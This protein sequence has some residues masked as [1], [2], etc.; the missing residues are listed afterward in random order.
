LK[1]SIILITFTASFL[2]GIIESFPQVVSEEPGQVQIELKELY[3]LSAREI[4]YKL[5]DGYGLN[6]SFQSDN[7]VFDVPVSLPGKRTINLEELLDI[8]ERNLPYKYIIER[9]YIIFQRKELADNYVISGFVKDA[10]TGEPMVA[11]SIYI[12]DSNKG[13]LTDDYG[14]FILQ[15]P[16]GSYKIGFKYMGYKTILKHVNLYDNI[17]LSVF[18]ETSTSSI[19][20]VEIVGKRVFMG[21]FKKGRTIEIIESRE[22]EKLTANNAADALHARI[23]GVWATKTSGAPGDH[24]KIRIRGINSLFASVDPLYVVD[25]VPVPKVNLHS[26]GISDLNINDIESITV[27]KDASSTAIYGYRG[28]NGVIIIDTKHGGGGKYVSF[29]FKTGVQWFNKRYD[30][31]N[32]YDFLQTYGFS[33]TIYNTYFLRPEITKWEEYTAKYPD[34]N[35]TLP[36]DDWQDYIFQ[37]GRAN[38][39]QLNTGGEINKIQ[40]Y[41]SGNHYTHDGIIRNSS[42][43]KNSLAANLSYDFK[44]KF[45]VALNYKGSNQENLNNIDNYLGNPVIF[46]GINTEPGFRGTPDTYLNEGNRLLYQNYEIIHRY[47]AQYLATDYI[48]KQH[49]V[50]NS[51]HLNIKAL[52]LPNL[53]I[54]ASGAFNIRQYRYLLDDKQRNWVHMPSSNYFSYIRKLHLS[55]DERVALLNQNFDLIYTLNKKMQQIKII[56]GLRNYSDNVFWSLDSTSIDDNYMNEH[57]EI[58]SRGSMAIYGNRGSTVRKIRSF[59]SHLNYNFNNKYTISLAGNFSHLFEDYSFDTKDFFPSVALNWNLAKEPI[60]NTI[61]QIDYINLYANWGKVGNYPLV[62]LSK[63]IYNQGSYIRDTVVEAEYINNLANHYIKNEQAFEYNLG[64]RLSLF[65]QRL[66]IGFDYYRKSNKDLILLHDI[67]YYYGG[68]TIMRN[69]GEM[70]STGREYSIQLVPVETYHFVWQVRANLSRNKQRVVSLLDT[71][72]I[73]FYDESELYPDFIINRNDPLGN[74]I[75]YKYVGRKEDV[76]VDN[77]QTEDELQADG[78]NSGLLPHQ[79]ESGGLVFEKYDTVSGQHEKTVIGNSIP[80]YTFNFNSSFRYKQIQLD[81]TLYGAFGVQKYN[82]TRASTYMSGVNSDMHE[83]MLDTLSF[84]Q[85]NF[86]YES[87]YFVED[88]SFLR[89]KTISVSYSP[90]VKWFKAVKPEITI[91]GENLFTFTSYRGYDPETSVYTDNNFSDNAIDR[92]A[93]PIPMGI[94]TSLKLTF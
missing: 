49:I 54:N 77:L 2:L 56:C 19:K 34:Y 76:V 53:F 78:V 35:L 46:K 40:Y 23:P 68:G 69:I 48:N 91:T 36:S 12:V 11:V 7:K 26:L 84:Y 73:V 58:F 1:K 60:L 45:M 47:G 71:V 21:D 57:R 94:Y 18:L 4:L 93:Y 63:D 10:G 92:G 55:S 9:E 25:G 52:V 64:T 85:Y 38:E 62:S 6:I 28:G 43:E 51:L 31:M 75:G 82:A 8:L 33:D 27:L 70:R 83:I 5:A 16:P 22:I 72:P 74:I 42:Y 17:S 90:A 87:S 65:E 24:E 89:I 29:R 80:D 15:L 32:T 79:F 30:L 88:A 41:I 20:E 67:P 81:I 86:I 66:V 59:I 61:K 37:Q 50:S 3:G 13:T 44:E 39:Y 14:R